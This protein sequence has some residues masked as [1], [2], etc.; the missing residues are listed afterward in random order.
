MKS[1]LANSVQL[2]SDLFVV[3][4]SSATIQGPISWKAPRS[5]EAPGPLRPNSS[6]LS[7]SPVG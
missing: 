5:D 7:L 2:L 1:M 3:F 6:Q 4:P